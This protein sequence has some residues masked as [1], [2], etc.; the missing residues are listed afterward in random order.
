MPI[1]K[2]LR[3][4]RM[5]VSLQ[6]CR[7]NVLR[8]D[9]STTHQLTPTHTN[10]DLHTPHNR[11]AMGRGDEKATRVMILCDRT[12]IVLLSLSPAT[13]DNIQFK[14]DHICLCNNN[15]NNN[16]TETRG[17]FVRQYHHG[18]AATLVRIPGSSAA[19]ETPRDGTR[20]GTAR[21]CFGSQRH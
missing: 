4:V 17:V 14:K 7:E 20:N 3:N 16:N 8:G 15:N 13:K 9:N 1:A 12:R 6:N 21:R 11:N 10:K 18:T 19:Q 2:N 5:I